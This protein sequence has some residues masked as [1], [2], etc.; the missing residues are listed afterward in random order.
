MENKQSFDPMD[1]LLRDTARQINAEMDFSAAWDAIRATHQRK[2]RRRAAAIRYGSLAAVLVV[3]LGLGALLRGQAIAPEAALAPEAA[4]QPAESQAGLQSDLEPSPYAEMPEYAPMPSE[5][6]YIVVDPP[7]TDG[8]SMMDP[9]YGDIVSFPQLPA[10]TDIR[11]LFP[12][13]LPAECDVVELYISDNSFAARGG[14]YIYANLSAASPELDALGL[15][16]GE[17][18]PEFW[19]IDNTES[20]QFVNWKLRIKEDVYLLMSF[21]YVK[22][23]EDTLRMIE[24]L[25]VVPGE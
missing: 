5:P 20:G 15:R 21:E 4:S 14:C 7:K 10:T 8:P 23:F 19:Q 2:A 3:G 9:W 6:E 18:V 13:W 1:Q 25:G 24:N 22:D 17:G 11:L 16:V 12:Y